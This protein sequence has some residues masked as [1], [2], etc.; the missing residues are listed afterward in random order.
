MKVSIII[1]TYGEESWAELAQTRA[2]PSTED[3]GAL[4]VLVGHDPEGTIAGVRNAL[5]ANAEGD[6][7]CF[8]DADDELADNYLWEMHRAFLREKEA[9]DVLLTPAVRKVRK[10][11]PSPPT[12]YPEVPLERA[13]WLIVGTLISRRLF[14][15][16]GGFGEYPHGFEDWALWYKAHRLGARVVRVPRAVYVQHVNPQSK[17][18]QG[19]RD[20]RWQAATHQRVARELEAWTP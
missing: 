7:L 3:Q 8:L 10:G 16:T 19:W 2:A 1:A 12:F 6:W 15:E 13:N 9:D 5:A 17:H 4:E 11:R 14:M 20:R 18:R